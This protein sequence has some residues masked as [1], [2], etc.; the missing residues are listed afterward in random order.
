[1]R[2]K[3][4]RYSELMRFKTFEDRFA[5]LSLGDEFG[6]YDTFT[7]QARTVKQSLYHSPEWK[8]SRNAVIV[9]DRCLDLGIEGHPI[10]GYIF[11]HHMNPINVEM[12][13]IDSLN[14]LLLDPEFL[15]CV[16][17]ETHEAIHHG[18]KDLL[19]VG[20]VERYQNDTCPWKDQNRI[21][22]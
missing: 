16:S 8:R 6:E 1:M 2:M 17:K 5:Y 19:P 3:I 7:A 18:T 20:L 21:K 11:I 15:I 14:G 13:G 4:R 22:F 9:R 10:S 12:F